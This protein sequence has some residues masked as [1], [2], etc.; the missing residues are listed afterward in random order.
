MIRLS[1]DREPVDLSEFDKLAEWAMIPENDRIFLAPY[2]GQY[3]EP[4][5]IRAPDHGKTTVRRFLD[6]K[7]MRRSVSVRN[8]FVESGAVPIADDDG[9]SFFCIIVKGPNRGA[10][11][12]WDD[13]TFVRNSISN[14]VCASSLADFANQIIY[15]T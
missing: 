13:D 4:N 10:I 1:D 6:P 2:M 5:F 14:F 9:G 8:D 3:L 11:I 7:S 15:E 12:Y